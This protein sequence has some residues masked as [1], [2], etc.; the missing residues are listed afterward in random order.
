[1]ESV[2]FEKIKNSHYADF[3]SFAIWNDS[4][5]KDLLVI[6]KNIETLNQNIIIVGLNANGSITKFQN[7]HCKHRGGRDAWLREAFDHGYFQG[8]YMTDIIKNDKSSRQSSVDLNEDNIFKNIEEFKEELTF[9][10]CKD[11]FIIAM[12]QK[13]TDILKRIPEL[14]RN[15]HSIPHY[16]RRKPAITKKEFIESVKK[17]GEFVK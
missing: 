13:T 3:V 11:P 10:G 17:L 16:A 7:F 15:V 5:I 1:M 4:D 8:A 12:G 14:A 9:I 2:L 6:E